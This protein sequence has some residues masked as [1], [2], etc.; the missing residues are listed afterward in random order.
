M[1]ACHTLTLGQPLQ[2]C[3]YLC[4]HSCPCVSAGL[5]AGTGALLADP[6]RVHQLESDLAHL[7]PKMSSLAVLL[8]AAVL[9]AMSLVNPKAASRVQVQ[10][11]PKC[12]LLTGYGLVMGCELSLGR[13]RLA[14]A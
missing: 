2:P 7:A 1:L 10:P 13:C 9:P 12:I 11:L 6:D 14:A 5:C 3:G 4:T 8:R